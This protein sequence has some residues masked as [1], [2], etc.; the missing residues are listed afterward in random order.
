MPTLDLGQCDCCSSSSARSG[1]ACILGWV[2]DSSSSSSSS[3]GSGCVDNSGCPQKCICVYAENPELGPPFALDTCPDGTCDCYGSCG[4]NAF[5][6]VFVDNGICCNG[7][8]KYPRIDTG[9]CER[10]DG[11]TYQATIDDCYRADQSNGFYPCGC[12]CSDANDCDPVCPDGYKQ[13][14]PGICCPDAATTLEDGNCLDADGNL[15]A[16]Q[17]EPQM[18]CC[19]DNTC[20][21]ITD[22]PCQQPA[23]PMRAMPMQTAPT[24]PAP[25]LNSFSYTCDN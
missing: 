4:D 16:V 14:E 24:Q 19:A 1:W 11:S 18:D 6:A 3:S 8:C 5:G 13:M 17:Y 9:C 2:C 22:S 25:V 20:K 7:V 21:D 15:I 23:L 12:P 10:P